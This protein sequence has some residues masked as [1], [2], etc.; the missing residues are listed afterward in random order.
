MLP[1]RVRLQISPISSPRNA[2][3]L[4]AAAPARNLL[5]LFPPED[6]VRPLHNG[7]GNLRRA[8]ALGRLVHHS[9]LHR[10]PVEAV[11]RQVR[12]PVLHAPDEA[13]APGQDQHTH[14]P[15]PASHRRIHDHSAPRPVHHR[16][17]LPAGRRKLRADLRRICNNETDNTSLR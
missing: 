4:R 14:G 15:A 9:R 5:G 1:R 7:H 6:M 11:S 3:S 17:A 2:E 13:L 12:V 16:D 8:L 10:A